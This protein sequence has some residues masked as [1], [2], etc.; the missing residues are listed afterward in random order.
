MSKKVNSK[1]VVT[2]VFI[3]LSGIA[4][5]YRYR[6]NIKR[7]I[8]QYERAE[9]QKHSHDFKPENNGWAKVGS[10][11]VYG[12]G[13]NVMF[14]PYCYMKDSCLMMLVSDRG[15]KV[16]ATVTSTDGI[17]W[18]NYKVVL[19]GSEGTWEDVVNR[20]CIMTKDSM[21]YLYYTGQFQGMSHIGVAIS[22]DGEEFARISTNPILKPEF[23]YEKV[24]VMNPCVIYDDGA[25]CFKMWYSAGDTYEPDV[26][27]YAESSDGI[28][29]NKKKGPVLTKSH[30]EWEKERIG[31]CQVLKDTEGN[32]T[33]YYIGYQNLDVARICYAE[34]SDGIHWVRPNNNLLLSPTAGSWDSDAVYKPTVIEWKGKQ[35]LYYN[36]RKGHGEYIGLATRNI[37]SPSN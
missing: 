19:A 18:G 17:E 2:V 23:E 29:W 12:D 21:T 4:V 33:I 35:L 25:D 15:N 11:P 34:S 8:R 13:E 27:C 32:Y 30:N 5:G 28:N 1:V 31:G 26:I 22:K 6:N 9:N 7:Q 36:G 10:T 20:G 37:N 24:S 14:D 3:L 16:L